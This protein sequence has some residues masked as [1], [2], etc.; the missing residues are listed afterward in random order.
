MPDLGPATA[1][2][3]YGEQRTDPEVA[4]AGCERWLLVAEARLVGAWPRVLCWWFRG[5]F[6]TL[7]AIATAVLLVRSFVDGL[8]G[9]LLLAVLAGVSAAEWRHRGGPIGDRGGLEADS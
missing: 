2:P 4:Y 5:A 3:A 7:C 6:L 8:V 9:L 1:D